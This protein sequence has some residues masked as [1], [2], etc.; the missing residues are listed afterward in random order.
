MTRLYATLA[1]R[2]CSYKNASDI[3]IARIGLRHRRVGS[4]KNF[5]S[6]RIVHTGEEILRARAIADRVRRRA[7]RV[8]HKRREPRVS[9]IAPLRHFVLVDRRHHNRHPV[10]LMGIT[11][12]AAL[13]MRLS[14]RP[15]PPRS[16]P[17]SARGRWPE[18][19]HARFARSLSQC[20]PATGRSRCSHWKWRSAAC[21]AGWRW[22]TSGQS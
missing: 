18:P 14:A 22:P 4:V 6:G 10:E 5:D 9:G 13:A 12:K 21:R 2:R 7:G 15:S 3:N 11:R 16:P 20:L 19:R 8:T 17:R 1:P